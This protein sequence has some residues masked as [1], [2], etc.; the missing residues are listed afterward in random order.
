VRLLFWNLGYAREI[1]GSLFEYL[2][3]GRQIF[4]HSVDEQQAFIQS[5]VD[6]VKKIEPDIFLY[7]EI[8]KGSLRNKKFNQHTYLT[9]ML[10]CETKSAASK[11]KSRLLKA[12]P[13]HKGNMN[14]TCVFSEAIIE[15]KHL[16]HGS[17]TLVQKVTYNEWVIFCVHLSLRAGARAKQLE[18]LAQWVNNLDANK[19]IILCGDFNTLGG[20][21]ELE[22]LCSATGLGMSSRAG[23]TFPAHNPT[24]RFDYFLYKSLDGL[25]PRIKTINIALSD[26]RPI[27]CEF[28]V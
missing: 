12:S 18:E 4:S 8:S 6:E 3:N 10:Q 23:D 19:N 22:H 14:G 15:N 26:H 9:S 11:Y 5:I 28:D 2:K 27:L 16:K 25:K 20:E 17:K 7:S 13:F 1:D 24:Q 21:K